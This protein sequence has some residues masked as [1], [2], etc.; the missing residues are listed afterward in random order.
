MFVFYVP[1]KRVDS[2]SSKNSSYSSMCMKYVVGHR[3]YKMV[4]V[5]I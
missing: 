3:I 2:S 5:L 1:V 4:R